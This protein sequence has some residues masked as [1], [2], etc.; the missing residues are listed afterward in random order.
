MS[1]TTRTEA[2]CQLI[3]RHGLVVD[4]ATAPQVG[5]RA[6]EVR[7]FRTLDRVGARFDVDDDGVFRFGTI[8]G[9]DYLSWPE[10]ITALQAG[11][12]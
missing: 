12:K 3:E 6:F 9:T 8:R 1:A 5:H 2:I 4:E 11:K 10:F 7:S